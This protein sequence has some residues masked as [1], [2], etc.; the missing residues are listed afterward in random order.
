MMN[1]KNLIV[2]STRLIPVWFDGDHKFAA[3]CPLM[4][5]AKGLLT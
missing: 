3:I 2:A 4:F 5:L 1:F